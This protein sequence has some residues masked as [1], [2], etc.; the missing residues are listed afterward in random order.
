MQKNDYIPRPDEDMERWGVNFIG[1]LGTIRV[2]V[3]FPEEDFARL[4]T[5]QEEFSKDYK[6]AKSPSTES[7]VHTRKKITTRKTFEKDVRKMVKAYLANNPHVTDEHK[8]ALGIT[9]PK[10][11]RTPSPVAT[12]YPFFRFDTSIL[13]IIRVFFFDQVGEEIFRRP[14]G[15]MGV[16]LIY[17]I[18]DTKPKN[19]SDLTRSKFAK[20]SPCDLKFDYADR[21][22][23]VYIAGRWINNVGIPGPW[24][25]IHEVIIP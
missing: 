20:K 24:S 18:S 2:E 8:I 23:T 11:S 6:L 17:V 22:K 4:K 25:E 5:E 9:I 15:Q 10:D 16:E 13:A 3:G 14:E 1:T 19:W 21:G 7:K 12:R